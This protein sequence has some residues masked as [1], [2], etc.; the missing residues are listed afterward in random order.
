VLNN[1]SSDSFGFS[2]AG[3]IGGPAGNPTNPND[4]GIFVSEVYINF[5]AKTCSLNMHL[6]RL[7]LME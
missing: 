6:Y 4:E 1:E 5:Q 2:L 7:S 3:G